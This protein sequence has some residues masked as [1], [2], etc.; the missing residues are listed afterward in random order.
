MLFGSKDSG[1]SVMRSISASAPLACDISARARSV[2][3][4]PPFSRTSSGSPRISRRRFKAALTAGCDWFRRSAV[5][6]TLRSVIRSTNT[7]NR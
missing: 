5:R 7:R 1:A 6:D 2:G 4:M 3:T